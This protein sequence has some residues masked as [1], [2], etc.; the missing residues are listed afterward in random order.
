MIG[1]KLILLVVLSMYGSSTNRSVLTPRTSLEVLSKGDTEC[2]LSKCFCG[3][4]MRSVYIWVLFTIHRALISR[5]W[6]KD[7]SIHSGVEKKRIKTS[8]K[9][10]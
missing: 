10:E 4:E 3:G 1:K 9:Y 7:Y 6:G 8:D 5:T 2:M